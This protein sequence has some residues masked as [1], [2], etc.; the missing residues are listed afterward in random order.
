MLKRSTVV[1]LAFAGLLGVAGC[2][3]DGAAENAGESVDESVEDAG[4]AAEEATED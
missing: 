3:D 1:A 4:D 2:E